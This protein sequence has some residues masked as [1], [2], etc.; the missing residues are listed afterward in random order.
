MRELERRFPAFLDRA[1]QE[2]PL[3]GEYFVPGVVNAQLEEGAVDIT[4]LKTNDAWHG[5][6]YPQ[7]LPDVVASLKQL[8]ESGLYPEEF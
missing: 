4:V 5:V 2:N 6:T 3:K 8:R 1:L 7:D